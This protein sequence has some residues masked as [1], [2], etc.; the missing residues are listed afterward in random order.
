MKAKTGSL[1][2]ITIG[3]VGFLFLGSVSPA[4]GVVVPEPLIFDFGEV[5]KGESV[6]ISRIDLPSSLLPKEGSLATLLSPQE[7]S[8]PIT[9]GPDKETEVSVAVHPPRMLGFFRVSV[10]LITDIDDKSAYQ[11]IIRGGMTP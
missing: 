9:L 4:A 11:M 2:L 3:V 7:S 5:W 8:L 6:T 10:V 1:V